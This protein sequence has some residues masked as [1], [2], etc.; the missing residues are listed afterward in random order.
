LEE[1][2]LKAE[3]SKYKSAVNLLQNIYQSLGDKDNLK[4]YQDKYDQAD[5]KFVN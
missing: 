2:F 4:T 1:G 3:R 5:S